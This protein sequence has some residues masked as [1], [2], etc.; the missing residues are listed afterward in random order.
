[1]TPNNPWTR[2]NSQVHPPLLKESLVE[3]VGSTPLVR[4]NALTQALPK[5]VEVWAKLES[6][7]PSGSIE[8]RH[9]RQLLLE[10]RASGGL[11]PQMTL[12]D[13]VGAELGIAYAMLGAA[14]GISVELVMREDTCPSSLI[15]AR[16]YGATLTLVEDAQA[17]RE[18]IERRL[19]DEPQG[20]FYADHGAGS[21]RQ[22]AHELTTATELWYQS[23]QRLTHIVGS[24]QQP[25]VLEG[26][27]IGLQRYSPNIAVVA[28]LD[29]ARPAEAFATS[30]KGDV[31]PITAERAQEMAHA[32]ALQ[33]GI[34]CGVESGMQ[35]A[36]A[37]EL[38]K[39][40]TQGVIITL[41]SEQAFQALGPPGA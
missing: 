15:I 4:L 36:A 29:A 24:A 31:I 2:R 34:S 25:C 5:Q 21:A 3:L 33:E 8:D 14:M 38:A 37:L 10:A 13:E 7:N 9:A 39:T 40:L 18:H 26:L 30:L 11:H 20:Y 27:E 12:I 16:H 28:A 17:A 6:M 35:V 23:G 41:I 22:I 32:L 1:M 19:R